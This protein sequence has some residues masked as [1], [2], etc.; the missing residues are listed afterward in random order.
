MTDSHSREQLRQ[1]YF[2]A[3]SKHRAGFLLTPLEAMIVDVIGLHP[4]YET[5]IRG[6][7]AA[8]EF[9]VP[10]G[11]GHAAENPYLHMALHI[12]VREQAA[13]DRPPGVRDMRRRLEALHGSVHPADHVMMQA[14]AETL[15]N[16]QRT[17]QPPDEASYL[18]RVRACLQGV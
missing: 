1:A 17:G 3:W 7:D 9:E 18:H 10:A 8:A 11:G 13:I 5:V 16:A 14:L 15:W 4:E 2:E 6:A 12:A